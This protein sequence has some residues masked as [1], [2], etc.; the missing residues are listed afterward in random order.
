VISSGDQHPGGEEI[1]GLGWDERRDAE[2]AEERGAGRRG[3]RLQVN[4]DGQMQTETLGGM[5]R[6]P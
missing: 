3:V 1:D 2:I 6:R 5:S 4:A